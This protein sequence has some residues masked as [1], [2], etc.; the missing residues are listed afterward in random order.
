MKKLKLAFLLSLLPM[1]IIIKKIEVGNPFVE[2]YYSEFFY[3]FISDKL[4]LMTGW[5]SIP[6]GDLLYLFMIT[7]LIY[8]IFFRIKSSTN[9][10]L[11]LGSSAFVFIFLFYMLWGLNYKRLTI[12][13][14]LKINGDFSKNELINFTE[15]LIDT[16]NKKH[17]F[18][19]K[20]DSIRPINE[21]SFKQSVEISKNN[22]DKLKEKI[23][24]PIIK[25]DY[26]NI[27]V[28]KSLFSLP[29]TYMGFSGYIN[30]FTNEANINYKIPSTSL[31]F[32][33]NHEI[34]HQL[35]IASEKDA[36]FISYLMLISSDDEYLK[37]CGLSYALRL[38]LNELSKLDYE[39]Y[40]YFLERVNKGIIK[41]Y[42]E[43]NKFWKNYEGK[44]EEVSK[45][46]YDIYLKQNNIQSGI[47]NYNESISLILKYKFQANE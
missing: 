43:I 8:F 22:I 14:H 45:K 28:K 5:I 34:A 30:P 9:T 20:N 15:N 46:S 24:I 39:K 23:K 2:K 3:L 38:C 11:N 10:L 42:V 29:L 47:K 26:K 31:I 44:I 25:S 36:N 12:K 18:L 19:F 41:D 27:S 13:D 35:G 7:S 40:R 33:I 32:V 1:I 37:Y 17:V 4:R 16:I 21:Y 6:I